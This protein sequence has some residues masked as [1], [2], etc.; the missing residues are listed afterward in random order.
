MF[1]LHRKG[2]TALLS[3]WQ[4]GRD[5]P[6]GGFGFDDEMCFAARNDGSNVLKKFTTPKFR[7]ARR[8]ASIARWDKP[9]TG[10]FQRIGAWLNMVFIDHGIFR[11]IYLNLHRVSPKFWRAAQPTPHQIERAAQDGVK[12]IVNLRGG[13]EFGSWPLEREACAEAGLELVDFVIRSRGAPERE[14]IASAKA[15]FDGLNY[16]VLA[17]CKSGADR[18]GFMSTLYLL[19]HEQRP[20]DEAIRQLSWRYGHFKFAKTGI[21]DAFFERYR[22]EGLDKGI[23]FQTWVETV[24]DPVA[25]ERE[26]K[27]KPW[28]DWLVEHVLRRE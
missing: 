13:R 24:Y 18:A 23:D 3:G 6:R 19:I 28:A 15:F 8:Q 20:L 7:H 26:F 21:L 1:G 4:A 16:P 27:T 10:F 22:T 17:H 14:R 2:M 5:T 11:L 9:I 12:T 25:L